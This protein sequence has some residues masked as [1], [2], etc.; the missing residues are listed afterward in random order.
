MRP[1]SMEMR[2]T[3]LRDTFGEHGLAVARIDDP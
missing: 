2:V 3:S 1:R